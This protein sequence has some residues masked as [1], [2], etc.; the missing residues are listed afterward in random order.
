MWNRECHLNYLNLLEK[1]FII[2]KKNF[3]SLMHF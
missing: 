1:W 2:T 3:E